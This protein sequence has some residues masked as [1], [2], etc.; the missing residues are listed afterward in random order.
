MKDNLYKT[1]SMVLENICM[2]M[3][4]CMKDHG[5]VIKGMAQGN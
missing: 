2:K 3:D 1:K 4:P 5:K